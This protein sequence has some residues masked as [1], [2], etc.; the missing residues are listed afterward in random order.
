VPINGSISLSAAGATIDGTN[1][2]D[3]TLSHQSA[4]ATPGVSAGLSSGDYALLVVDTPGT[5]GLID[6]L[7]H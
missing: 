6:I 2:L 1:L 7:E 5:G 3:S 4:T